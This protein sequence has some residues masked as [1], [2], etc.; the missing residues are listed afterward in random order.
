MSA[1]EFVS[2]PLAWLV[3]GAL[4]MIAIF[5]GMFVVPLYA[6]LTTKVHP[7][8]ASRTVAANNLVNAGAMV[9][10]S[11]LALALSMVGIPLAEQLLLSAAMCVVSAWLG[12][13]LHQAEKL[14]CSPAA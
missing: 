2:H 11:V 7:S 3:L 10:G 8:Q 5:G 13:R 14:A 1:A 4:L 6:F 9:A 12:A